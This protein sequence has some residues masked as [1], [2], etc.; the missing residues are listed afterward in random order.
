[1]N[2]VVECRIKYIKKNMEVTMFIDWA[3]MRK[4]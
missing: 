4:G 2:V 1:M 3:Y